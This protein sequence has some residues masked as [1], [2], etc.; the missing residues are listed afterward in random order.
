[1]KKDSVRG[2]KDVFTFTLTQ[3]LK[4][5]TYIVSLIIMIVSAMIS[6]PVMNI[7]LKGNNIAEGPEKSAVEKVYFY[8]MTL[9][10]NIDFEREFPDAY[11]NIVFEDATG[12][13]TELETKLQEEEVNAVILTLMEDENYC[14]IQF[15][16]SPNGDVTSFELQMLGQ[17]IQNAYTKAK[18]ELLGLTE[19]QIKFFDTSVVS[20]SGIVDTKSAVGTFHDL[21]FAEATLADIALDVP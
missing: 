19:E 10:R 1:M 5:K 20:N 12:D 16:R 2:W 17:Y 13:V 6:M 4:S 3:T 8:N 14:Y 18:V 15:V 7:L 11:R 21:T 9:C